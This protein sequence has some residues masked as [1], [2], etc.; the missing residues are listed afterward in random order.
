MIASRRIDERPTQAHND[1]RV[2]RITVRR[3]VAFVLAAAAILSLSSLMDRRSDAP[4]VNAN[5]ATQSRPHDGTRSG[6]TGAP[7]TPAEALVSVGVMFP[8]GTESASTAAG[9]SFFISR[10][11]RHVSM[12][13]GG[14][15]EPHDPRHLHSL[16]LLI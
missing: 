7:A 16:S 5:L 14:R 11:S 2:K 12:P 9:S 1:R 13:A 8:T 15:S 4:T 3:L 6:S 10:G